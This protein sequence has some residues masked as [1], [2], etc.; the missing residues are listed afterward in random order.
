MPRSHVTRMY[1]KITRRLSW[2]FKPDWQLHRLYSRD[3]VVQTSL[4]VPVH[5]DVVRGLVQNTPFQH[6]W[7]EHG[8][9]PPPYLQLQSTPS[10][11]TRYVK[12]AGSIRSRWQYRIF[13]TWTSFSLLAR[14][15]GCI[16]AIVEICGLPGHVEQH[17]TVIPVQET[18]T[19]FYQRFIFTGFVHSIVG[20]LIQKT[21]LE[22]CY[23][24]NSLLEKIAISYAAKGP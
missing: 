1:S 9:L 13:D 11:R 15:C 20:R 8:I 22:R 2:L 24:D 6:Y 5:A 17:Y 7:L 14:I 21:M 10:R 19:Q 4:E 23:R 16:C 12:H 18:R 3:F